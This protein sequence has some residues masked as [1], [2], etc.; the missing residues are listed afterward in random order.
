MKKRKKNIFFHKKEKRKMASFGGS[1]T[2]V[3]DPS[4]FQFRVKV[5]NAPKY[6]RDK[7]SKF[8]FPPAAIK[9]AKEAYVADT[10]LSAKK[11][12][13]PSFP[14]GEIRLLHKNR[15]KYRDGFVIPYG[16]NF[17]YFKQYPSRPRQGPTMHQAFRMLLSTWVGKEA[18]KEYR[19]RHPNK[20]ETVV[21]GAKEFQTIAAAIRGPRGQP[22]AIYAAEIN[23]LTNLAQTDPNAFKMEYLE[24]KRNAIINKQQKKSSGISKQD[25]VNFVA[26]NQ[27]LASAFQNTT[28]VDINAV[29]TPRRKPQ[30]ARQ[31]MQAGSQ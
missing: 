31:P 11:E 26:S 19:R 6:V 25:L 17:I 15:M 9:A 24:M 12:Q 2:G 14:P 30:I 22:T 4:S 1:S 20:H 8:I 21:G 13:L 27:S 18:S 29:K 16:K 3:I 23:R 10:L 5:E 7:K 28:G